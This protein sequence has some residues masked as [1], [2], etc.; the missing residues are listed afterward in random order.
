M[1]RLLKNAHHRL[2]RFIGGP[3]TAHAEGSAVKVHTIV[4]LF[5]VM[6]TESCS[7]FLDAK[8][9]KGESLEES[10]DPGAAVLS[11][12]ILLIS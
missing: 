7:S 12:A 3:A 2:D 6:G 4:A 5:G 8:V 11:T 1:L 9:I 10:T